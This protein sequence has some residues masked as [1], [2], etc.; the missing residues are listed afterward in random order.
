MGLEGLIEISRRILKSYSLCDRCLGRLYARLGYGWDNAERGSAVKTMLVM[1]YH[2]AIEM[3]DAGAREEFLEMAPRIGVRAS[4]LYRRLTGSDLSLVPCSICGG[5]LDLFIEEAA[6]KAMD[7]LRSWD[8]SRFLVGVVVEE[9]VKSIEAEIIRASGSIY[10]EELKDEISR[11][12]GKRVEALGGFTADL[13]DPEATIV[14]RY[15]SGGIDI[16]VRSILIRAR[17]WKKW[18]MISQSTILKN[19]NPK[20]FSVQEA[21]KPLAE[22]F[23]GSEVVVHAFGR[24]DIDARMLGTGRGAVIEV[25][26]PRRR[27][28]SLE[29]VQEALNRYRELVEFK[30]EGWGRKGEVRINKRRSSIA[31]KI[32][33]ILVLAEREV[34]EEEIRRLEKEMRNR[35]IRQRTPTRALHRRK[36]IERIKHV[37]QVKCTKIA[38]NLL[39]CLVEA[40][41]GLY[42]KELVSGDDG[43]TKPSFAEILGT[44]VTCIEL[45]VVW[46]EL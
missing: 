7:L 14:V 27:R 3:G 2:Q 9:P 39:E 6:R 15:P 16:E 23:R 30:V 42:I 17:Y 32:Y 25:R 13:R 36:D 21:S 34:G 37:Y 45:D 46:T 4:G 31:R 1:R 18:R 44:D 24:E 11:E 22:L 29:E 41:G 35:T 5:S 40:S 19:G 12:I 8:I 20:Y 26:S 10:Y 38:D 43:R 28:A 33:R